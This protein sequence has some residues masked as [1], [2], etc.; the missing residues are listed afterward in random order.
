VPRAVTESGRGFPQAEGRE[1]RAVR[2]T[3][4]GQDRGQPGQGGDFAGEKGIAGLGLDRGRL[5]LR[6][7]AADR[8]GDPA[9]DQLQ[10]VVGPRL[11]A[12]AGETFGDQAGIEQLARTV[13]REGPAGAVGTAQARREADHQQARIQR[14]EGGHRCVE[15]RRLPGP[16]GLTEGDEPGAERAIGGGRRH[17]RGVTIAPLDSP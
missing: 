11:E 15:P 2:D 12:A 17:R 4:Q 6:W 14:P 10:P 9:V 3:A 8:V 5:V 7:H 13:S 16:V 1:H